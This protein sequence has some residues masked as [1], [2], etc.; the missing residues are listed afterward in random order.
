MKEQ[1]HKYANLLLKKGLCIKENQP[2]VI[3]AQLE[4]LDFIRILTEVACELGIRDIY[5]DWY[6]DTLKHIEMKYFDDSQIKNSSFW[7]KSIHDE[8]A[9]KDAAFLFLVSSTNV[10]HD[11]PSEKL[12]V[13]SYQSLHTRSLYRHLQENNEVSW[14]I[15]AVATEEWGNMIFKDDSN[16]K[17]KLWNVI[18]DICMINDNDPCQAWTNKMAQN[19]KFC[20]KLTNLNIKTLHYKNSLGTNL[21]IE[22]SQNNIWCGGASDIKSDN[23]IVNIPTEEVFTTPNKFKTNGVVYCSKPLIHSGTVINNIKLTFK[24]GR[25]TDYYANSGLEELEN[26]IKFDDE[27][28]MLGEV[29]LV[30][31]NSKISNSNILFYET[32]FDENAACHIALGN[33]FKEC[34][35]NSSE[36]SEEELENVGYNKSRNHVDMMIGTK[37]LSI[38]ATTYD[39]VEIEI[40]KNGSFNI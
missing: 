8:Y 7:N 22:L 32:L 10:M 34:I 6:D 35:K 5:Y 2:L 26:I 1:Y 11:I 33:G 14:C 3:N 15:A 12:K 40:F 17:E 31:Y 27:S 37:D 29:A 18:F 39:N 30:D 25:V 21:T 16:A 9:K 24:N 36:M 20:Q 23:L 28:S 19:K 38:T 4:S 13:A